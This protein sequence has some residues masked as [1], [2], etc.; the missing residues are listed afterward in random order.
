MCLFF[1]DNENKVLALIIHC[2]DQIC[3]IVH[4][5]IIAH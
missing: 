2:H 3:L 1:I 5:N 4:V